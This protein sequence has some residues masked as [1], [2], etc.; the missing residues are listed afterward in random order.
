MNIKKIGGSLAVAVSMLAL[1]GV[2]T[3]EHYAVDIT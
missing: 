3:A 1:N 2:A